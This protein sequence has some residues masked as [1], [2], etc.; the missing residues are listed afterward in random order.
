M[1]KIYRIGA[2]YV[3]YDPHKINYEPPIATVFIGEPRTISILKTFPEPEAIFFD[4]YIRSK[5][6]I[7]WDDIM[8][9]MTD[10]VTI[11]FSSPQHE[12]DPDVPRV[13]TQVFT[14]LINDDIIWWH[15]FELGFAG[16]SASRKFVVCCGL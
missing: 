7:A 16:K 5:C 11:S 13:F 4:S 1:I 8:G 15:C 10:Q 9:K 14:P 6:A 3:R 12:A 2:V